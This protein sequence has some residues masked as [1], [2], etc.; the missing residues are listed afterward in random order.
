MQL[1]HL[2]LTACLVLQSVAAKTGVLL[3]KSPEVE[4]VPQI[5]ERDAVQRCKA[6]ATAT[7]TGPLRL[8]TTTVTPPTE[9]A[10]TT[11]T[12]TGAAPVRRGGAA[13]TCS[14]KGLPILKP[15][16]CDVIRAAC[17]L[18]VKSGATTRTATIP[19]RTSTTGTTLATRTTTLVAAST[20]APV[21]VYTS[22]TLSNPPDSGPFNCN[23][24]YQISCDTIILSE[25]LVNSSVQREYTACATQCDPYSSCFFFNF[26]Q[27]TGSC[28]LYEESLGTVSEPG[29]F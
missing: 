8:T 14:I 13:P 6:T 29:L 24:D 23:C 22:G 18:F 19:S 12:V 15:F 17:I 7:R 26:N 25:T 3:P 16:A 10:T 20:V 5:E 9:T 21:P 2:F 28:Q 1:S 4:V 11:T 27:A